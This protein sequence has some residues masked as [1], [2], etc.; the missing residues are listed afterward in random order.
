VTEILGRTAYPETWSSDGRFLV[1][2]IPIEDRYELWSLD[3][4]QGNKTAPLVTGMDSLDEPRFSPDGR[5]VTFNAAEAGRRSEIYAVPFPP[6]G[7]RYQ[8]SVTSGTQARWRRDGQELYYLA[9]AGTLM[10]VRLPGGDPR[11][12]APPEALFE[13]RL[14][15]SSGFDQF[16]PSADGQRFLLRR[17]TNGTGDRAPVHVVINWRAQLDGTEVP[18]R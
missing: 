1:V 17:P 13:A 11:R 5:W 6:T 16:A 2:G 8:L 12:A 9:P 15:V 3:L 7:E 10:A 14:E 4:A 18:G